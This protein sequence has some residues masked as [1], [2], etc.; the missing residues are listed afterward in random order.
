MER[1]A[2]L[3]YPSNQIHV[4]ATFQSETGETVTVTVQRRNLQDDEVR[5][6]Q[7]ALNH[8][9]IKRE[10]LAR[11]ENDLKSLFIQ[12]LGNNQML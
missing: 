6:M 4:K 3:R 1:E 10:E 7:H 12:T 2:R 8:R 9:N 5:Q 11:A